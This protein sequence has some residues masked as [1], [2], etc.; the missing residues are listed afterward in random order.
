MRVLI[1]GCGRVGARLAIRLSNGGH[2]VDVIDFSREA[3]LRLGTSFNGHTYQGSGLDP[4]LLQRAGVRSA[5]AVIV[6]TA[7]DNRNVMIAQLVQHQYGV[8]RVVARLH[9][10][11]RAT[12]YR[13]MGIET[14]CTTTVLE[15]LLEEYVLTG[16]FPPL[17]GNTSVCGDASALDE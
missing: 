4:E 2:H 10:P 1:I 13:E 12:K 5:D 15:G 3:F 7:G 6:L 14:L 17:P 9:D 11:V 8:K 16:E